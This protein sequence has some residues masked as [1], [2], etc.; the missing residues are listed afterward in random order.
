LIIA[1]ISTTVI[2]STVPMLNGNKFSEWKEN[3]FFYLGYMELDLALRV[4]EPLTL[5][6]ISTP[7]EIAKHE[8]WERSNHLSLML[9][10]SHI[11]KGIKGSI[12]ECHKA[13]E[14]IQAVEEQ[15]VSSDK[16]LASTLMKKLLSKTFNNSRSVREHIMKMRDMSAQLKSIEFDI[17]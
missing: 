1:A 10:K 15:F 16:A 7:Q 9:M 3:L 5:T 8:R 13:T 2:E 14:F 11:I 17:S 12:P 6:D 4:D